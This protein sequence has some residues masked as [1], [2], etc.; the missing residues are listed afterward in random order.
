M[1]NAPM[2]VCAPDIAFFYF[3]HEHRQRQAILHDCTNI[4]ELFAANV[5][6]LKDYGIGLAAI[7]A[8]MSSEIILYP[9]P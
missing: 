1:G 4:P 5:V 3:R 8:R 2:A 9:S 7:N 6:K